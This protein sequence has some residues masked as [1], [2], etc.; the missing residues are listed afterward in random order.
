M[1]KH[2]F[3]QLST[4]EQILS[5]T[6]IDFEPCYTKSELNNAFE[7][8]KGKLRRFEGVTWL[9]YKFKDS[10]SSGFKVDPFSNINS[11]IIPIEHFSIQVNMK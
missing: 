9:L 1:S 2:L 7:K 11:I 5:G 6:E 4:L 3:F 8:K 10:C